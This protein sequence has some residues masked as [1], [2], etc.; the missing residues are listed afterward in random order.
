MGSL[1]YAQNKINAQNVGKQG[2]YKLL[3]NFLCNVNAHFFSTNGPLHVG[4]AWSFFFPPQVEIH[5]QA[6]SM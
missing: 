4:L 6:S 3:T 1:K 5:P 2:P